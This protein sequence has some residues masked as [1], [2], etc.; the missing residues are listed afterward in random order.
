MKAFPAIGISF[1]SP[2]VRRPM[3]LPLRSICHSHC[4]CLASAPTQ[5]SRLT[6]TPPCSPKVLDFG[7]ET[8]APENADTRQ[9]TITQ[10]RLCLDKERG[11]GH[12]DVVYGAPNA[13]LPAGVFSASSGLRTQFSDNVQPWRGNDGREWHQLV[14]PAPPK[15]VVLNWMVDMF[16][17]HWARAEV[18][19]TL[20][21]GRVCWPLPMTSFKFRVRSWFATYSHR[22]QQWRISNVTRSLSRVR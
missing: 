3:A 13:D 11:G 22:A 16:I 12:I 14:L 17:D 2:L 9:C 20:P 21:D 6:P 7:V 4:A 18:F 8:P 1:C 15:G 5:T 10:V 19:C